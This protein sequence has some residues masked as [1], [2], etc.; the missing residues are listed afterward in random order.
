MTTKFTCGHC[1]SENVTLEK[2]DNSNI[3]NLE[4]ANNTIFQIQCH[5]CGFNVKIPV[6]NDV[7]ND[8]DFKPE[9]EFVDIWESQSAKAIR[10]T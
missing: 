3:E 4:L 1:K 5:T 10:Q 8:V 9:L 7:A 2:Q 6:P